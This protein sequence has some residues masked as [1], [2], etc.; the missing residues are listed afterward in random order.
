MF[1]MKATFVKRI[2]CQVARI[3]SFDT[4]GL[5][6]ITFRILEPSP[7]KDVE[8]DLSHIISH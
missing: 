2:S 7:S 6:G 1:C 4:A 5:H 3:V 8:L